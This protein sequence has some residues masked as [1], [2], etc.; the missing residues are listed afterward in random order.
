M[1]LFV[2]K[3]VVYIVLTILA[4]IS[5]AS[6][7]TFSQLSGPIPREGVGVNNEGDYEILEALHLFS[8]LRK[9]STLHWEADE[10]ILFT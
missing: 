1:N 4:I 9:C 2:M 10:S 5:Q 8:R 6:F 7:S 3:L